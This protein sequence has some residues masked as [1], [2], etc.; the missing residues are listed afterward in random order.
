MKLLQK[1]DKCSQK[2]FEQIQNVHSGNQTHELA[3]PEQELRKQLF[4]QTLNCPD[5]FDT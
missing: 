4:E 1:Q 3:V 2:D 5:Y